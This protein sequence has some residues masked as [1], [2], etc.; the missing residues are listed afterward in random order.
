MEVKK[1]DRLF[2]GNPGN[3]LFQ[4]FDTTYLVTTENIAGYMPPLNNQ[5]VLTVCSCGD[6]FLNALFNGAKRIDLFDINEFTLAVLNL[7][8]A[9]ILSL[10]YE[11]FLTYFGIINRDRI[12]D[13]NLYLKIRSN[14][15]NYFVEVFDYLYKGCGCSG[16]YMIDYTSIFYRHEG[17]PDIMI[18][19]CNYLSEG[20]FKSLKNILRSRD[21]YSRFIHSNVFSLCSKLDQKYDAI[22]LSNIPDY[23]DS[24]K[25]VNL[26]E[27]LS[28]FLKEDG[29]LY[30]AYL[31]R[32]K[33]LANY[34]EYEQY[35]MEHPNCFPIIFPSV[36]RNEFEK[37]IK[38]KVFVFKN[39]VS[40]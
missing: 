36:N 26:V 30:F 31:Y 27:S 29:K 33:T 38:D 6:H 15:D 22:F 19:N 40:K 35:V 10:N 34:L 39:N 20:N 9:A 17:N 7:K 32:N 11:E 16:K 24:K 13:Y 37:D 5:D 28:Q 4:K 3:D 21:I 1:L 25:V 12:L 23:N 2:F 14:L 18:S 8:I